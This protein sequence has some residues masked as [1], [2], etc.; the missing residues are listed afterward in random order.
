M[1]SARIKDKAETLRSLLSFLTHATETIIKEWETDAQDPKHDPLLPSET[2]YDVRQAV[3]GACGMYTDLV[4][5]PQHRLMELSLQPFASRALHVA[6]TASIADIIAEA[7]AGSG[8]DLKMISTKSGIEQIKLAQVLHALCSANVFAEIEPNYFVNNEISQQGLSMYTSSV[9][10]P[11]VLLNSVQAEKA[12]INQTAFE[13]TFGTTV[14]DYL[15]GNTSKIDDARNPRRELEVFAHAMIGAGRIHST[16]IYA[17]YP[18]ESLRKSE[19]VDVGG[20]VGGMS[21]DLAKRFPCLRFI[22]QDRAAVIPQAE[23]VWQ[24]ELP[25]AISTQRVQFMPHD[26]LTEQPVKGANVYLMRYVLHDWPDEQCITILSKLRDAMGPHSRILIVDQIM[27]TTLGSPH[28]KRAPAPLPANYGHA[29]LFSHMVDLAMLSV[30]NSKERTPE[31][32]SALAQKAGLKVVKIWEC[33]SI[34][35]VTE[36]RRSD[37]SSE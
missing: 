5:E 33:R 25:E 8:V 17:D 1:T 30:F 35:G 32:F 4:Q 11:S 3:V 23:V 22:I 24:H 16:P 19:I 29:Q 6:A 18:W 12:G 31:E 34:M 21:L 37:A 14:W 27:R 9:N 2:L 20:G 10:L 26:F 36:M 7:D 15:E 13:K 28:L